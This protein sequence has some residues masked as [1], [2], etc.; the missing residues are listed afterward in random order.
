MGI[1]VREDTLFTLCFTDD[2]IVI[3]QDKEDVGYMIKNLQQE[4]VVAGLT[5][6]VAKCE[7]F[8]EIIKPNTFQQ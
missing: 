8:M 7:F 3:T 6:D 1:K 4:Y 5:M 2:Q